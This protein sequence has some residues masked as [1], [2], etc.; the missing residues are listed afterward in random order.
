[1]RWLLFLLSTLSLGAAEIKLPAITS[2]PSTNQHGHITFTWD[3]VT[4]AAWYSVIVRSNGVEVQRRYSMVNSVVISNLYF[5]LEQYR[6]TAIATNYLGESAETPPAVRSWVTITN[7]HSY[8]L[9]NWYILP[10]NS[11]EPLSTNEYFRISISN[12]SDAKFWK[13]D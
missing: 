9:S 3:T 2:Q 10:T 8:D 12:W 4:N 7:L 6:F 11:F 1:M 13:P 5:P